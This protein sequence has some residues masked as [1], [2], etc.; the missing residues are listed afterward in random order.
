MLGRGA[1]QIA[2]AEPARQ[3]SGVGGLNSLLGA[4]GSQRGQ[5]ASAQQDF[6]VEVG[7]GNRAGPSMGMRSGPNM[8]G[9]QRADGPGMGM[10]AN[11]GGP[12]MGQQPSRGVGMQGLGSNS[13]PGAKPGMGPKPAFGGQQ[14]Q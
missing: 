11:M 3:G 12:S 5:P 13:G 6:N 8:G 4:R 14:M 1:P 2:Y 7:L 9:A 10:R